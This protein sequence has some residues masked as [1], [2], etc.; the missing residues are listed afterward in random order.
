MSFAFLENW[1]YDSK[2][3]EIAVQVSFEVLGLEHGSEP[4]LEPELGLGLELLAIE[5]M[6]EL[7]VPVAALVA[8]DVL[9][10]YHW[11]LQFGVQHL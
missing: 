6:H 2:R 5:H 11:G 1:G 7:L 9:V 8:L 4:G 3:T 10:Y